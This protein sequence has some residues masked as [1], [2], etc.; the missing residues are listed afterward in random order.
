ME[1]TQGTY[2][3]LRRIIDQAYELLEEVTLKIEAVQMNMCY[4]YEER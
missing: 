1:Q 4:I 3:V 2:W